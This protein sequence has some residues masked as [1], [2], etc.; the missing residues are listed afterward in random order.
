MAS[1][2][3]K[4]QT[5]LRTGV[6]GTLI[7]AVCCFTPALVILLGVVGLSAAL[8]WLDY[9]LFA[10]LVLFIGITVYAFVRRHSKAA[11]GG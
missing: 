8:A 7:T 5:L 3:M 2:I 6:V 11:E 9:V 4:N 10:A 1:P